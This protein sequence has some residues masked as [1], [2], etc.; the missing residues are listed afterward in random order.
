MFAVIKTGGKQYRVAPGDVI[1]VEKLEGAAGDKITFDS[2]LMHGGGAD[3]TVGTPFVAG[4]E[5]VG[6]VLDQFRDKKVVGL[7][8]R[9]RK[10]SSARRWGHRQSLTKVRISAIPGATLEDAGKKPEAAA[11]PKADTAVAQGAASEGGMDDLTKLPGVTAEAMATLNDIGIN[12]FRQ[13]AN[14]GPSDW[15][16]VDAVLSDK[17]DGM[18]LSRASVLTQANRLIETRAAAASETSD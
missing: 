11:E 6:E 17:H 4:A 14:W 13:V 8:K 10:H 5:V 1:N 18:T 12:S 9:R 2:V 3:V 7:K 15:E 16:K